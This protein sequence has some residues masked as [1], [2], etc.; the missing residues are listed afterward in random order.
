MKKR[1]TRDDLLNW[2]L[3]KFHNTT[4]EEVIKNHTKEVL[5]DPDWFKL[6]PVT[7]AQ[8][9]EWYAWAIDSLAK[10]RKLSKKI[11][12]HVFSLD[13]L[14]SMPYYPEH[15]RYETIHPI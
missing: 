12:E 15:D 13:F 4:V 3:R 6:Y 9:D 2:W 7:K 11:I 1:L 5:S 8:H 14:D 10:E